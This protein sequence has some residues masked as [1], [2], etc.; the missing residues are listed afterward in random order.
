MHQPLAQTSPAGQLRPHTPQWSELNSTSV[1]TP[2][3]Q[4]WPSGQPP[5]VSPPSGMAQGFQLV[6]PG[7]S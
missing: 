4:S 6:L 1:Q 7:T 3:Q 5:Q 2:S